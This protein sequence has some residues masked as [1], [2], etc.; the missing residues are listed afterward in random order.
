MDG[1][2]A[3]DCVANAIKTQIKTREIIDIDGTFRRASSAKYK[4]RKLIRF[5]GFSAVVLGLLA[6]LGVGIASLKF[7]VDWGAQRQIIVAHRQGRDH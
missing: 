1:S 3:K 7:T 4:L 2:S 5:E 6:T